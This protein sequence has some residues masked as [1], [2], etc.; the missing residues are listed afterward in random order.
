MKRR[1]EIDALRGLMLVF[2]TITHLPVRHGEWLGQPFGFVSAAEGFVFLSAYMVGLIYTQKAM[3]EGPGEMRRALWRRAF[4]VYACHAALLLFLFTVVTWIGVK[5]EQRAITN[6]VAFYLEQPTTALWSGFALVYNPPLLDILPMYVL[7]MLASPLA[8]S[9]GLLRS[10]WLLVLVVSLAFWAAT[11]FGAADAAYGTALNWIGLR[12]PLHRTSAFDLTA[13][14]FLWVLG[15]WVGAMQARDMEPVRRFPGWL[16]AGALVIA[17]AGMIW[18]HQ[19]GQAP[20]GGNAQLNLLFDK[21]QLGP[22]RLLNFLA[23]FIVTVVFG[24]HLA[25]I[26]R[27]R[28]L[29]VLGRASLPVFCA[30]LVLALLA[31]AAFGDKRGAT[32]FWVENLVLFGTFAALYAVAAVSN[33]SAKVGQKKRAPEG[34]AGVVQVKRV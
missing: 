5:S 9:L 20:F 31:L 30:H 32:P 7:F 8:L 27:F 24:G 28:P 23:L 29:E 33:Y 1:G 15:L 10:G 16:I 3:A 34:V 4:V 13:W 6:L 14:Q 26:A 2:M 17:V 21:W 19:V 12:I 11:Q 25:R 22:L 18:R